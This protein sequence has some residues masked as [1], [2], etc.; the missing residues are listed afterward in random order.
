MGVD[1]Y[2]MF[3]VQLF[4][5]KMQCFDLCNYCKLFVVDGVVVFFGLQNIIDLIYNL[6]KNIKCGLYW[7][8]FMVCFDGLVVF[9]VNVIFFSDWYSEMDVVFE[10]IDIVYVNI[11]FGD[12]DCQVVLFGFG[13]EVENN[14]CFFFVLLY[15]V[16][17]K[18]MIVSF[19]FVLDEVLLF[20]VIVVVDWGVYVE[21]FVF[22]EGDQVMV[23]YVQCSYYEVLFKVGVCIWMYCKFYIL[24]IKMLMIDDEVVVIGLSNMDMCLFGFNF[25]VLMFVCGEE[26][27]DEMCEVEDKYCL[28]SCEFMLEEWM[29]QLLCL[30]VF[31]NL[32]CFIFVLQ[33]VGGCQVICGFVV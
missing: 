9:S 14:F 17:K 30:M 23:Y 6:K 10:E 5:G 22:E 28:F 12:F 26:F 1:W 7:V 15:V 25:E 21:F 2:F 16:K 27:V 18:I 29:E 4:K 20:V 32:V 3:L 8:D 24:Y 19:Y 31:D 11:G 33:Q 13:F